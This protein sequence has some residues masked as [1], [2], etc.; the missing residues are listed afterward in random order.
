MSLF[1]STE[2]ILYVNFE[3]GDTVTTSHNGYEYKREWRF[4]GDADDDADLRLLTIKII[5]IKIIWIQNL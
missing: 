4:K 5:W 3:D 1:S 2:K